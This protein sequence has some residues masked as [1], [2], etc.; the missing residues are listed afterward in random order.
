MQLDVIKKKNNDNDDNNIFL[1][2]WI[3]VCFSLFQKRALCTSD[4]ISARYIL[5][6]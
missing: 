4:G 2:C 3:K 1:I 5:F 6:L